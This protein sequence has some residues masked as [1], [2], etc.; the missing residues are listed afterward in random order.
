ME[1]QGH[2][3][4]IFSNNNNWYYASLRYLA[5][6]AGYTG[7][8]CMIFP[9]NKNGKVNKWRDVYCKRGIPVSEASL[10]EC[11]SEFINS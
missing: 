2:F 4:E 11:I 7:S 5:D 8:E 9:S 6:F 1:K 3:V 10:K